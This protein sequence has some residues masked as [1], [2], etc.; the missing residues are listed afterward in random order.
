MITVEKLFALCKEEIEKGNGD[1]EIILCVNGNEFHPL[2][3]YFSSPINNYDSIY[4]YLED[5]DLDEDSV[6]VLN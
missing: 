3:N 2:E 5:N 1:S 6:I 4:N